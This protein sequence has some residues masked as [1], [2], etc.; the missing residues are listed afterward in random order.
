[1]KY[2]LFLSIV[3]ISSTSLEAQ[4]KNNRIKTSEIEVSGVCKMC[5][6]RIENA[7]MQI[8]VKFA[9]WDKETQVLKVVY[10]TK[11]LEEQAIHDA[12]ANAGHDT[13][14]VKAPNKLYKKLPKCCRYRDGVKV[15]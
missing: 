10:K 4:V 7:A 6:K 9:R 14:K 8:G 1:M 3:L 15:H 2:L 5:K 12:I 11:E 13:N